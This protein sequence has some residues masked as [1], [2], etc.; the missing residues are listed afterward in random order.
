MLNLVK[1][2]KRM[3][4]WLKIHD[5]SLVWMRL[6]GTF[7][8][9]SIS[10]LPDFLSDAP[11]SDVLHCNSVTVPQRIDWFPVGRY[12]FRSPELYFR[13]RTSANC[14]ISCRT[15]SFSKSRSAFPA[16]SI[17]KST[18]FLPDA[19]V[20]EVLNCI[21]GTVHQRIARF[22]VGRCFVL[23][24]RILT[25]QTCQDLCV[26]QGTAGG[27]TWSGV[28]LPQESKKSIWDSDMNT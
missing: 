3:R 24:V 15:L 9:P 20:F 17:S 26:V 11:V 2:Q 22:P 21:S 12:R 6:A 14:P 18:D 8:A 16:P 23:I 13:H 25:V 1:S 5:W 19:I 28:I 7:P 27:R 4:K 10:E